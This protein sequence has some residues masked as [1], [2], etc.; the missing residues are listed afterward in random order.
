M[1]LEESFILLILHQTL[2]DAGLRQA[3]AGEKYQ[4]TCYQVND[5]QDE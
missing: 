3:A 4:Q 5:P 1:P 2:A